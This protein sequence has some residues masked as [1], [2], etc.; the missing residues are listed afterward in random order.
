LN[1]KTHSSEI[2]QPVIGGRDG[3]HSDTQSNWCEFGIVEKVSTEETDRS[4]EAEQVDKEGGSDRC[5]EPYT[6]LIY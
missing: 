3:C 6:K 5:A 1:E 4:E 2:P